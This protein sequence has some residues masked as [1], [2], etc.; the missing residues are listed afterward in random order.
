M[1]YWF[2]DGSQLHKC[3]RIFDVPGELSGNILRLHSQLPEKD[4]HFEIEGDEVRPLSRCLEHPDFGDDDSEDDDSED[5]SQIISTIPEVNTAERFLKKGRYKSEVTNL[6]KCKG[7]S[8]YVVQLLGKSTNGELVFEKLVPA[9]TLLALFSSLADYKRW[10]LQLID[11]L[12][13]LHSMGIVH[14]DLRVDNLLLSEDGECLVI[15]D[16]E[17]RW[18]NRNAP[19]IAPDGPF[20]DSGRTVMWTYTTLGTA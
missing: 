2:E 18:G 17:S 4:G 16:L 10:I 12:R 8:P 9:K 11:G 15:C 1:T 20:D 5:L 13:C 3:V 6:L 7:M 19:E 14:R